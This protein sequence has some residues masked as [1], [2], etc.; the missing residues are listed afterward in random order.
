MNTFEY[1]NE[2]LRRDLNAYA[3]ALRTL[4]TTLPCARGLC[5]KINKE[6]RLAS[7]LLAFGGQQVSNELAQIL[8]NL[9]NLWPYRDRPFAR[10]LGF[11]EEINEAKMLRDEALR[12]IKLLLRYGN[13]PLAAEVT[14]C[15]TNIIRQLEEEQALLETCDQSIRPHAENMEMTRKRLDLLVAAID[16]RMPDSPEQQAALRAYGGAAAILKDWETGVP[17]DE[18]GITILDNCLD[19]LEQANM[20]FGGYLNPGRGQG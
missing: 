4:V 10:T 13:D 3:A 2:A 8:F 15:L 7:A 17:L 9:Q 6:T 11:T 14:S 12:G 18:Q 19:I 5:E 20:M 16:A 1:A